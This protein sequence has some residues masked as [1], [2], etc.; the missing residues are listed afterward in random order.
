MSAQMDELSVL[1]EHLER[2]RGVTLQAYAFIP[3]GLSKR[4][5][6]KSSGGKPLFQAVLHSLSN[7]RKKLRVAQKQEA[8]SG[9]CLRQGIEPLPYP[10][11]LRLH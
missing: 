8:G 4:L 3:S 1:R 2:Y 10:S 5:L 6:A 11:R 9:A 7:T